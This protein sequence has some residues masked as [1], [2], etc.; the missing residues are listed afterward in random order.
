MQRQCMLPSPGGSE[1][2]KHALDICNF[3]SGAILA[4]IGC[5]TGESVGYINRY[6]DHRITG[7][8]HDPSVIDIAVKKGYPCLCA[9][10]ESLPFS[11][12]SID[13][14]FYQCSFSKLADPS[15]ALKEAH[16]VLKPEGKII[17]TDFYA[18][19]R[20]EHFEGV[21]G[22]VEFKERIMLKIND[23][24]FDLIFFEDHTK[25]LH[26]LWGQLIFDQGR[27]AVD[28]M[29]SGSEKIVSAKCRY[30]IFIAQRRCR[31]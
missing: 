3:P 24:G 4:D 14:L 30:G 21:M 22:R 28:S 2:T 25:E 6:T 1:L 11:S 26:R 20:E 27:D 10:A 17:I 5:G 13:G 16:R 23:H 18:Q 29:L 7:I 9:D 19:N 8:D 15:I 12:C 31:T